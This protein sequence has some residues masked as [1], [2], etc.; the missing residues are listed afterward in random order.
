[1]TKE[2][3][4]VICGR[5]FTYE[6]GRPLTCG[7]ECWRKRKTQVAAERRQA[8]VEIPDHVHGTVEGYTNYKCNCEACREA[9]TAYHREYR[10]RQKDE[11]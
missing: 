1:M 7:P 2:R 11:N 5:P 9:N 4:C 8:V 10:R 3:T 6:R